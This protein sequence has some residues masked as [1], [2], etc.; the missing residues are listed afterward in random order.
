MKKVIG[1]AL[2]AL[3][4]TGAACTST[5]EEKRR[6]AS[7]A[8]ARGAAARGQA[9]LASVN[10]EPFHRPSCQWAAKIS[11]RNLA[12]YDSPQAAIDDGHRPCKS[13]RPGNNGRR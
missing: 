5:P 12:G 11:T 7:H 10:R 8:A 3:L 2:L 13:C 9:Y 1:W 4:V 6:A